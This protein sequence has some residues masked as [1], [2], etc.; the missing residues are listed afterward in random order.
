MIILTLNTN[1][2][3][4]LLITGQRLKHVTS[5]KKECS[6]SDFMIIEYS[7]VIDGKLVACIEKILCSRIEYI[8]PKTK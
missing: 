2:M 6:R 7:I 5:I 1:Y 4:I 3:E 8:K